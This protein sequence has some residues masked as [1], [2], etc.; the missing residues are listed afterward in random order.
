MAIDNMQN[1]ISQYQDLIQR[2]TAEWE[3]QILEAER[4]FVSAVQEAAH[5]EVANPP[6][7]PTKEGKAAV[8]GDKL[9]MDKAVYEDLL[10]KLEK[11]DAVMAANPTLFADLT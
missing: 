4:V 8:P 10:K 9:L 1:A 11:V 5:V 7:V 6:P 3:S 2:V